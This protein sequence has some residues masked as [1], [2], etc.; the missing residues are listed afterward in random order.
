MMKQQ[1]KLLPVRSRMALEKRK[2]EMAIGKLFAVQVNAITSVSPF[3]NSTRKEA[4][5]LQRCLCYT[6][7]Q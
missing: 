5:K 6:Q 2:K 3:K 4:K 7:T 1:Q